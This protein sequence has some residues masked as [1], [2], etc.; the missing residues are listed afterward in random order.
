MQ[1]AQ[2]KKVENCSR[3]YVV[4]LART[5][6][7]S[8]LCFEWDNHRV[9][10]ARNIL[11]QTQSVKRDRNSKPIHVEITHLPVKANRQKSQTLIPVAATKDSRDGSIMGSCKTENRKTSQKREDPLWKKLPDKNTELISVFVIGQSYS[12]G[13]HTKRDVKESELLSRSHPT[14]VESIEYGKQW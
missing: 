14:L 13:L 2:P 11:S 9:H 12:K 8:Y 10:K 7:E 3:N 5:T 4:L 1:R 6:R